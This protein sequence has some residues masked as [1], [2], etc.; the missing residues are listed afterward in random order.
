MLSDDITLMIAEDN[1][2][3][4]ILTERYLRKS[5]IK[6]QIVRFEDGE[7]L[8]SFIDNPTFK[9]IIQDNIMRFILILDI[10]MPKKNGIEVLSYMKHNNLL[11][12]I[13]TLMF[14]SSSDPETKT[15]CFDLGCRGFVEK[16]PGLDL[17]KS[18][19]DIAMDF[20]SVA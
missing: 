16:P 13:P 20:A 8:Q 2:A 6:N 1:D 5:G 12:Q 18:I 7:V 19:T 14:S 11:D 4:Y 15:E 3:Q 17:I 9:T 10:Q